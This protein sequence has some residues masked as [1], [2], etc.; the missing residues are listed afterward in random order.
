MHEHLR[1]KLARTLHQNHRPQLMNSVFRYDKNQ[2][3]LAYSSLLVSGSTTKMDEGRCGQAAATII[4]E[5]SRQDAIQDFGTRQAATVE[6]WSRQLCR[7]LGPVGS[8]Y[9]DGPWWFDAQLVRRWQ[10]VYATDSAS[11]RH[12]RVMQALRP[13]LAI[14]KEWNDMLRLVTVTPGGAGIPAISGRGKAKPPSNAEHEKWKVADPNTRGA[15]VLMIGG[16]QQVYVPF[17]PSPINSFA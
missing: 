15:E 8:G 7:A 5:L 1:A 17:V 13:M 11:K 3:S 4:G 16:F 6:L 14:C 12:D 2:R 9:L 10:A